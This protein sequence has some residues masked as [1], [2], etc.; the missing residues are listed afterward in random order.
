[1]FHL[2]DLKIQLNIVI[3]SVSAVFWPDFQQILPRNT[4]IIL[5]KLF[6]WLVIFN[7]VPKKKKVPSAEI[8]SVSAAVHRP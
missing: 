8:E 7:S 4:W 2:N 5:W 6:V 1:M 3:P